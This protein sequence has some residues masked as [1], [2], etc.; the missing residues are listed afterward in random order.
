MKTN[1][2]FLKI[3]MYLPYPVNAGVDL[4]AIIDQ[5]QILN[6]NLKRIKVERVRFVRECAVIENSDANLSYEKPNYYRKIE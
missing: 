6:P 3:T 4:S 1:K 5:Q 2:P